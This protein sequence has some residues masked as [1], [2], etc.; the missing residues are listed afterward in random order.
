MD[1][2]VVAQRHLRHVGKDCLVAFDANLY[3]VPARRVR[4]RQLVEIRATRSQVVL[5]STVPDS[6]GSTL[7]AVHFRVVGRGARIV[8]E[9]HSPADALGGKGCSSV[10]RE[11]G[12]DRR[13]VRK[14]TL[15]R[16]WHEVVRRAPRRPSTLDPYLD[17]LQQRWDEGEHNAVIL[18]Q[19]L[20]RKGYL[21]HYQRVKTASAPL[22][23]GLPLDEPR[24]RPPSPREAARWI[25]TGP[26]QHGLH[27]TERLR[28]L[29]EH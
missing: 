6:A 17:H 21:G 23:R 3:S 12:L 15:A 13:T 27:T 26:G 10:A 28:R 20:V 8:D 25:I 7:L 22:R 1:A 9:R 14:Y 11:L 29:L 24:E 19:E 18:Q 2:L 4:P 5:H 16:T